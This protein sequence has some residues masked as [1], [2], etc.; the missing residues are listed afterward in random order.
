MYSNLFPFLDLEPILGLMIL[1]FSSTSKSNLGLL[2]LHLVITLC[3]AMVCIV[4]IFGICDLV[5]SI[6]QTI[7]ENWYSDIFVC[8]CHLF[9]G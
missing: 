5:N 1:M 7:A 9:W 8:P 2:A 4:V 6:A 3:C